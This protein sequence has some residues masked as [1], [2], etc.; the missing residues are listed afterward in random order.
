MKILAALLFT[1]MVVG[2]CSTAATHAP[3]VGS[4]SLAPS[5]LAPSAPASSAP[6]MSAAPTLA[7]TPT[8]TPDPAAVKAA[9]AKAYLTVAEVYNRAF[10]TLDHK[11]PTLGTLSKFRAYYKAAAKI[12][13]TF[14]AGVRQITFPADTAGDAHSLVARDT[15][16]Q[17]L[18]IEASGVRSWA[19]ADSVNKAILS[20]GRASTE[21]AN[22]V[23][24]DLGLPPVHL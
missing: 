19:D 6:L 17:A 1:I 24:S 21:T 11:Y 7:A 5:A 9:A 8:P 15:A 12:D 10:K 22:L 23:R 2:A 3:S 18:E 4:A 16:V 20:A 13:G 14:I